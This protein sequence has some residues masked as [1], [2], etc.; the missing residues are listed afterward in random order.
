MICHLSILRLLS[1]CLVTIITFWEKLPIVT[2]KLHLYEIQQEEKS[3]PIISYPIP[4]KKDLPFDIVE[5]MEEMEKERIFTKLYLMCSL[6]S[7]WNSEPSLL[8]TVP[9]STRKLASSAMLTRN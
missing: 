8:I 5:L 1:L 7:H 6:T 4:Y 2:L 9:S 3:K